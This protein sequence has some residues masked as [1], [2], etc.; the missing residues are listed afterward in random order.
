MTEKYRCPTPWAHEDEADNPQTFTPSP[1]VTLV[2]NCLVKEKEKNYEDNP[3]KVRQ[4]KE[5]K[6]P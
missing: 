2:S 3:E 6:G 5:K 1:Y 4:E